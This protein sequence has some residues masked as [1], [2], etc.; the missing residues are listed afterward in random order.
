MREIQGA[1]ALL[2]HR[3]NR[4]T[5]MITY[6]DFTSGRQS[7][8]DHA[9]REAARAYADAAWEVGRGFGA[10][11]VQH[12]PAAAYLGRSP[13]ITLEQVAHIDPA[14]L[15]KDL[16]RDIAERIDHEVAVAL[17][18]DLASL[19][20][21]SLSTDAMVQNFR[22]TPERTGGSETPIET[23]LAL[24]MW[25]QPDIPEMAFESVHF[26][27]MSRAN[28]FLDENW[29]AIPM[30]GAQAAKAKPDKDGWSVLSGQQLAMI[31]VRRPPKLTNSGKQD[32]HRRRTQGFLA[33]S[34]AITDRALGGR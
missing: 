14:S 30:L 6:V 8:L 22:R 13:T 5:K 11:A 20:A 17:T 23:A 4:N 21:R 25:A 29:K 32:R 7:P 3:Y 31:M 28:H 26:V 2:H 33:G 27:R 34:K 19:R 24:Y 18:A 16:R 12:E 10:L 9:T 15:D 1:S